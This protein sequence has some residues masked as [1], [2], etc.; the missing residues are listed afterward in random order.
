MDGDD[1]IGLGVCVVLAL[2]GIAATV[3]VVLSRGKLR[4]GEKTMTMLEQS[5][6]VGTEPA[7]TRNVVTCTATPHWSFHLRPTEQSSWTGA[8]VYPAGERCV[9]LERGMLSRAG[10]DIY[11]VR[12]DRTGQTGWIFLYVFELSG[13]CAGEPVTPPVQRPL[14]KLQTADL[15]AEVQQRGPL[16]GDPTVKVVVPPIILATGGQ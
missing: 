6:P 13:A 8:T 14:T 4:P 9:V 5:P 15:Q 7:M 10:A 1:K 16:G 12:I 2:V 11:K 3:G